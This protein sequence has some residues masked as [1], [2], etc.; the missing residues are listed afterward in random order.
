[1]NNKLSKV[2]SKINQL[3]KEIKDIDV[4]LAVNYTEV[5]ANPNFY[6][7]YQA[8]KDTLSQLMVDWETIHED[9]DKLS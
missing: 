1:M 8:K 9:L 2:E 5:I 3:E 6:E 4:E 7:D